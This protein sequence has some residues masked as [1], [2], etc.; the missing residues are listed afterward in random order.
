MALG[1]YKSL[2]LFWDKFNMKNLKL[3]LLL[4]CAFVHNAFAVGIMLTITNHSD[5]VLKVSF[6]SSKSFHYCDSG[7]NINLTLAP[8]QTMKEW[9][10]IRNDSKDHFGSINMMVRNSDGIDL[11]MFTS[12]V[13]PIDGP[14]DCDPIMFSTWE[15]SGLYNFRADCFSIADTNSRNVNSFCN[16]FIS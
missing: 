11:G 9:C 4:S 6:D 7:E 3:L 12:R 13:C 5:K 2:H 14:W 16:I 15:Q 10:G 8:H 1:R